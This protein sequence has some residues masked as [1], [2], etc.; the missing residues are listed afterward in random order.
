MSSLTTLLTTSTLES[1][2][3]DIHDLKSRG[4]SLCTMYAFEH[5]V[6]SLYRTVDYQ[7]PCAAE[8]NMNTSRED[9]S[10]DYQHAWRASGSES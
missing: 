9:A 10:N 4:L 7:C 1:D 2:I 6:K 8:S 3:K 5:I